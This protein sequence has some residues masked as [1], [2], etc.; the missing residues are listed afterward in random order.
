MSETTISTFKFGNSKIFVKK[1]SGIIHKITIKYQTIPQSFFLQPIYKTYRAIVHPIV[2][3]L[4]VIVLL[5]IKLDNTPTY[6]VIERNSSGIFLVNY[7]PIGI[8]VKH[9]DETDAMS[10]YGTIFKIS[11]QN[12]YL[13]EFSFK[14]KNGPWESINF[15]QLT[16][17]I[18]LKIQSIKIYG[19]HLIIL[20][21]EEKTNRQVGVCII[22]QELSHIALIQFIF[23][24]RENRKFYHT[25]THILSP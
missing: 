1:D 13:N 8:F 20:N 17:D 4:F 21:P 12:R 9:I 10:A 15:R 19:Y 16:L 25:D 11:V 24:M 14:Q 5:L 3:G 2:D 18:R 23:K 7:S 22:L 6:M